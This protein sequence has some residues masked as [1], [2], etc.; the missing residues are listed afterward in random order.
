MKNFKLFLMMFCATLALGT[1]T[2]C[3]DDDDVQTGLIGSWIQEDED[4]SVTV[5][6]YGNG[7]GKVHFVYKTTTGKDEINENFEYAFDKEDSYLEI[8][9]ST[10]EGEYYVTV[11]ASVLR[12]TGGGYRYELTRVK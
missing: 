11:T 7:K 10:L 6:F 2:A 12:L 9:G 1:F 8:I 4:S 3:D 5:S